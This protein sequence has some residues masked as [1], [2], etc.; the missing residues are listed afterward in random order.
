MLNP[1]SKD[2]ADDRSQAAMDLLVTK[3][4]TGEADGDVDGDGDGDADDV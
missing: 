2:E 1:A 3:E 4:V